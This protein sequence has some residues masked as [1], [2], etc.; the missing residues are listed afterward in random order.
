MRVETTELVVE[1]GARKN[2]RLARLVY[3]PFNTMD[4]LVDGMS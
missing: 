1:P 4:F 2:G 3:H